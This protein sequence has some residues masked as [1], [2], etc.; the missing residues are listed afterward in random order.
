MLKHTISFPGCCK[1]GSAWNVPHELRLPPVPRDDC[2]W[3]P[4]LCTLGYSDSASEGGR[5][6]LHPSLC[7]QCL[8]NKPQLGKMWVQIR[9]SWVAIMTQVP[10]FLGSSQDVC[11]K[12]WDISHCFLQKKLEKVF[13]LCSQHENLKANIICNRVK[14]RDFSL[15]N[16]IIATVTD[17]LY[18]NTV[19]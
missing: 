15:Y 3:L 16:K 8:S 13:S 10:Q 11:W 4:T 14:W 18:I 17:Y 5:T 2:S 6:K 12:A 9:A 19:L 1:L 7:P